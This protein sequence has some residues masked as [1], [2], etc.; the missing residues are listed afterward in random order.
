MLVP[1]LKYALVVVIVEEVPTLDWLNPFIPVT[2]VPVTNQ[3]PSLANRGN[4]VDGAMVDRAKV[5]DVV[6]SL[7]LRIKFVRGSS[8]SNF[9][10]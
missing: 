6:N 10:C 7:D 5:H 4:A 9:F 3:P 8:I 1:R 2:S